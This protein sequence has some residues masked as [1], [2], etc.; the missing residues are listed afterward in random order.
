MGVKNCFT[1]LHCGLQQTFFLKKVRCLLK[2]KHT[3]EFVMEYLPYEQQP[4]VTWEDRAAERIMQLEG[5]NYSFKA[6]HQRED[7]SLRPRG[8]VT[9][10]YPEENGTYSKDY[11][12]NS[13]RPNEYSTE[14]DAEINLK[15]RL[16]PEYIERSRE[17]FPNYDNY[18]EN[19]RIELLQSVFRGWTSPKTRGHINNGNFILAAEEFLDHDN[20]RDAIAPNSNT[21]GVAKRMEALSTA[22]LREAG[23]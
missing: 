18:S 8:R 16:I 4:A 12:D 19:L 13:A 3:Q 6:I 7:Y 20:Y 22:L 5:L 14:L 21:R 15:N 23:L 10:S 1:V 9:V 2:E 17:L 11:G